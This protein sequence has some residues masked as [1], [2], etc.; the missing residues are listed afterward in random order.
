MTQGQLLKE[1]KFLNKRIEENKNKIKFVDYD[2]REL[3]KALNNLHSNRVNEL[4]RI[5][6][7]I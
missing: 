7:K 5:K 6:E 3:L 4:N 1:L 2:Q